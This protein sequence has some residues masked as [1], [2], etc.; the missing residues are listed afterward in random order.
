MTSFLCLLISPKVAYGVVII[1]KHLR[2]GVRVDKRD[3]KLLAAPN[4]D[5]IKNIMVGTCLTLLGGIIKIGTISGAI[6]ARFPVFGVW[7]ITRTYFPVLR[8]F[9]S[10]FL[11]LLFE[12]DQCLV[13]AY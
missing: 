9:V 3:E 12:G 8:I 7:P 10:Y 2:K 6:K 4:S 5:W 1:S 13:V 11:L